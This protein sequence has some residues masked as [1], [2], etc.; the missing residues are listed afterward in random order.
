MAKY[1]TVAARRIGSSDTLNFIDDYYSDKEMLNSRASSSLSNLLDENYTDTRYRTIC[2]DC[3]SQIYDAYKEGSALNGFTLDSGSP[4]GK[5][6]ICSNVYLPYYSFVSEV[7]GL[8][9]TLYDGSIRDLSRV[10]DLVKPYSNSRNDSLTPSYTDTYD[11]WCVRQRHIFSISKKYGTVLENA[12]WNGNGISTTYKVVVEDVDT[13]EMDTTPEPNIPKVAYFKSLVYNSSNTNNALYYAER[14]ANLNLTATKSK[15]W[16]KHV[17]IEKENASFKC[18]IIANDEEYSEEFANTVIKELNDDLFFI[19]EDNKNY[20]TAT[21]ISKTKFI[22]EVIDVK[23]VYEE[24]VQEAESEVMEYIYNSYKD[25]YYKN[26]YAV[27]IEMYLDTTILGG[28]QPMILSGTIPS[29]AATKI[30]TDLK[31]KLVSRL[32]TAYSSYKESSENTRCETGEPKEFYPYIIK[33]FNYLNCDTLE[34]CK[35]SQN[36]AKELIK[37]IEVRKK[38]LLAQTTDENNASKL[39]EAINKRMDK[40]SGTF[41]LWYQN[42]ISID[43]EYKNLKRSQSLA[44]YVLKNMLVS[45]AV[46]KDDESL[47]SHQNNPNYIDIEK[48]DPLYNTYKYEFKKGDTIYILDD[49]HA[50]IK[51]KIKS[52]SKKYITT[53]KY[54]NVNLENYNGGKMEGAVETKEVVYRLELDC[55]LPDYYC[56]DND[57]SSLRVLKLIV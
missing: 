40:N 5:W 10:W 39:V 49:V 18:T 7:R 6:V 27:K 54:D 19:S 1:R 57:V 28:D 32:N 3:A 21:V 35:A 14:M 16:F 42:L 4:A 41:M 25:I 45:K 38:D 48:P 47:Y 2:V 44:T 24:N 13:F 12:W 30:F 36:F 8:D 15:D 29:Q 23:E 9:N 50:E 20:T 43:R 51:T 56:R 34:A 55:N 22:T 11:D 17:K 53:T 26:R 52:V 37:W 33:R 46:N 31:S